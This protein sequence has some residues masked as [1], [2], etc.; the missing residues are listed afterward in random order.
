M[1]QKGPSGG[2]YTLS[3][4]NARAITNPY[5]VVVYSTSGHAKAG[6][7]AAGVRSRVLTRPVARMSPSHRASRSSAPRRQRVSAPQRQQVSAAT[8]AHGPPA[9]PGRPGRPDADDDLAPSALDEALRHVARGWATLP[10][11][12]NKEPAHALIRSTRGRRGWSQ[13]RSSPAD[14]DEVRAWLELDPSTG[15]GVITGEPSGNLVVVDVDDPARAPELPPTALVATGRCPGAGHHYFE[16]DGK[17]RSRDFD[18][19]EVRAAGLY[20][21]SPLSPHRNGSHCRW[22]L[23]PEE[24]GELTSFDAVE[25]DAPPTYIRSTSYIRSTCPREGQAGS[26]TL[27]EFERNEALALR[28]AAVLGVPDGVE[29]GDTFPCLLH[30]DGRPSA[31]LWRREEEAHVLYRDWHASQHGEQRWLSLALVRARL[32]GRDGN[33]AVPELTV[34]KLRLAREAGLLEPLSLELDCERP[35]QRLERVLD[36]FVE[37]L[38]LRWLLEPGVPA[39]FSARF[40]AA[41]CGVGKREA[42]ESVRELHRAGLLRPAGRDPRGTRLWLPE[43]VRPVDQPRP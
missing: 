11:D 35:Q 29:V 16:G 43:G 24:A 14:E 5:F 36:G 7:V 31:S 10:V 1:R 26:F 41:W 9:R 13:L 3:V 22:L 28:L 38:A 2:A 23:S 39:P 18:W 30:R 33:L 19:G 40:A 6:A 20:V 25:L 34:W 12:R 8:S 21:V 27:S 37:L 15:I 17:T 32:A 4:S 42:H